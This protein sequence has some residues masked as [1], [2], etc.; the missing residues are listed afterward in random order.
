MVL[1]VAARVLFSGWVGAGGFGCLEIVGVFGALAIVGVGVGV[2]FG[3]VVVC[4]GTTAG[5]LFCG[6]ESRG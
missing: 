5:F 3:F 1:V 2:G 6:L 4:S